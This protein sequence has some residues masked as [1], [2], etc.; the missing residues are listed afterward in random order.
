MRDSVLA[1][2]CVEGVHLRM[3]VG[4]DGRPIGVGV[5][6]IDGTT[7]YLATAATLPAGRGQGAT[8]R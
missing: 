6:W 5:L 8:E 1:L 4:D 3:A 7:A 2:A